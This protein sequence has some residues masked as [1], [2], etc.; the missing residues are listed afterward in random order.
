[1]DTS[2]RRDR[3]RVR[4]TPE[5]AQSP[6]RLVLGVLPAYGPRRRLDLLRRRA[7]TTTLALVGVAVLAGA[8][9]TLESVLL[10]SFSR[11]APASL[12]IPPADAREPM[13]Q[14]RPGTPTGNDGT[15][16]AAS[17]VAT[18]GSGSD[19]RSPLASASASTGLSGSSP[20]DDQRGSDSRPQGGGDDTQ[21]A[22]DDKGGD[23]SGGSADDGDTPGPSAPPE[24]DPDDDP[25]SDPGP[26]DPDDKAKDD[27]GDDSSSADASSGSGD[28]TGDESSGHA[29]D[30]GD[31]PPDDAADDRRP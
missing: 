25:Q 18:N 16:P 2:T 21:N 31:D 15:I 11:G 12:W 3:E 29:G 20:G 14:A 4:L 8:A 7:A 5:S 28:D 22:P 17:F 9:A 26:R 10:P 24:A 27:S 1:M 13:K 30:S 23:D 19:D 6:T